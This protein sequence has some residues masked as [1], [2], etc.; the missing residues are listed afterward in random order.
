[1]NIYD[2][3][4][5]GNLDSVGKYLQTEN[6]PSVNLDWMLCLTCRHNHI[7]IV[8]LL[9]SDNRVNPNG[10]GIT[11]I[12]WASEHGHLEIV[13]YL[14]QDP[15]V[16]PSINGNYAIEV[17]ST[18]GHEKVLNLLLA[19][20]RVDPSDRN[21]IAIRWAF[22]HGRMEIVKILLMNK[23]VNPKGED[24]IFIKYYDDAFT[25]IVMIDGN[26]YRVENGNIETIRDYTIR[27]KFKHWQYRIG[28]EKY[29][30]A[31]TFCKL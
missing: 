20:H 1:M 31:L 18:Y 11:P 27:E 2:Y 21:N 8:K 19:D 6:I 4:K 28:G 12:C 26:I 24:G 10:C 3:C 25:E 15:R 30:Q 5:E 16:D 17:A 23:R 14:L 22:N 9:L 7:N 13:K 29:M